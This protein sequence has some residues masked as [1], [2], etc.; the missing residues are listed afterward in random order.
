MLSKIKDRLPA[1]EVR[2]I[3]EYISWINHFTY[4]L[5][6]S[7][8]MIDL[9]DL[10][11]NLYVAFPELSGGECRIIIEEWFIDKLKQ[12]VNLITSINI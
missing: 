8:S 1:V 6:P 9:N 7:C 2:K 12:E 5:Y 4:G 3:P 11:R 10:N